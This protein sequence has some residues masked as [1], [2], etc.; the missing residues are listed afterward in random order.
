M[1]ISGVGSG[2][3][4]IVDGRGATQDFYAGWIRWL[5]AGPSR[6]RTS[7]IQNG[8]ENDG[9]NIYLG[10]GSGDPA[11]LTLSGDTVTGGVAA[12]DGAGIY[13][14]DLSSSWT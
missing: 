11:D 9:A 13:V 10:D 2:P 12:S 4:P 3:A 6:W 5:R 7:T 14:D 8:A 1:F